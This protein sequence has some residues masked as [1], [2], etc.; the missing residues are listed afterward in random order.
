MDVN[1]LIAEGHVHAGRYP[2]ARVW[3]EAKLCRQRIGDRI[4]TEGLMMKTV[5][6]AAL[7][8]KNTAYNALAKR[9]RRG[10]K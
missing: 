5:I 8:G 9:L 6:G 2:L 10:D 7:S 3:S 4:A 1:L